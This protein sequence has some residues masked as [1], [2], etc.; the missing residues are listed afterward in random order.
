MNVS[1]IIIV[2]LNFIYTVLFKVLY[3]VKICKNYNVAVKSD[4]CNKIDLKKRIRFKKKKKNVGNKI[5]W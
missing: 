2:I 5:I 1:Q 4:N 3:M